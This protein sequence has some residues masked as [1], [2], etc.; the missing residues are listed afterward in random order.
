M[1]TS[2]TDGR[3]VAS[4]SSTTSPVFATAGNEQVLA[5]QNISLL[6][7]VTGIEL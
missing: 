3:L 1:G 5:G 2:T 7:E 4:G 6:E